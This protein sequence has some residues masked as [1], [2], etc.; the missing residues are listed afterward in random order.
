MRRPS[1]GPRKPHFNR[2]FPNRPNFSQPPLHSSR[3][4]QQ[5]L[6]DTFDYDE[7]EENFQD[8]PGEEEYFPREE[9]FSSYNEEPPILNL[10]HES[11]DK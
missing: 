11:F 7:A 4:P 2:R 8:F 3:R 10:D 6:R 1:S 5:T 9:E